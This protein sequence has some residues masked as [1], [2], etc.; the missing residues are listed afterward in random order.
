[1][2]LLNALIIILAVKIFLEVDVWHVSAISF[3]DI[4]LWNQT[5]KSEL[6]KRSVT[7][8]NSRCSDIIMIRYFNICCYTSSKIIFFL[9][10][11]YS[12]LK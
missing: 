2:G 7:V 8:N 3:T 1:M 5:V 9:H 12:F 4:S 6:Q 10:I 11:M